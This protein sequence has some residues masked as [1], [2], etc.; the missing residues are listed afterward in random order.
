MS[1]VPSVAVCCPCCRCLYRICCPTAVVRK[2]FIVFATS[3]DICF[4]TGRG[5]QRNVEDLKMEKQAWY[6]DLMLRRPKPYR[7]PEWK[8]YDSD[9][10]GETQE[11]RRDRQAEYERELAVYRSQEEISKSRKWNTEQRMYACIDGRCNERWRPASARIART[12]AR[13]RRN[14]TCGQARGPCQHYQPHGAAVA[15]RNDHH[16]AYP[17][18]AAAAY[19]VRMHAR[20]GVALE[21]GPGAGVLHVQG[22]LNGAF[23]ENV[24]RTATDMQAPH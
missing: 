18:R 15:Y 24:H 2:Q 9:H 21:P 10:E 17:A 19:H 23:D 4:T 8:E 20:A 22:Q 3:P 16:Y 7:K 6:I 11:E 5:L 1:A 13:T 14:V 12:S